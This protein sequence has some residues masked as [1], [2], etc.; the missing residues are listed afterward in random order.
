[1]LSKEA[2]DRLFDAGS[3]A[4]PPIATPDGGLAMAL[5]AGYQLSRIGPLE[6]P[7]THTKQLVTLHDADSLIAYLDVYK[8]D[9]ISR[10]FAEPG[11]LA[12][13]SAARLV[14]VLDYHKSDGPERIA[15]IATYTPRYSEAWK[16]WHAACAQPLKQI[17]FAELIEECR[18]DIAEPDAASLLDIVRTFKAAKKVD[19]DS[20]T[21]QADSTVKLHYSETVDKQGSSGALPELMQ[22]GIP[23]YYRGDHY[24][25]PLFVRFRVGG[26]GVMFSLKLDRA[27]VIEDAAFSELVQRVE[28]ATGV[29]VHSGRLDK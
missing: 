5:P 24:K 29:P 6:P 3:Q 17:E 12:T 7:L 20:V 1:M 22:L 27:D 26:G 21:Y 8:Q 19:Y 23:V 11:F 16:R 2:I 25:I 4:R 13:G 14:A 10:A 15:H 28:S 18:A 9:G